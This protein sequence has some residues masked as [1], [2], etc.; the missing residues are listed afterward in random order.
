MGFDLIL[1]SVLFRKKPTG[2]GASGIQKRD[3]DT[4]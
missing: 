1:L 2:N 4:T 3:Q